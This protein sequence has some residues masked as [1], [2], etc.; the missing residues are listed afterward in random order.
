[1]TDKAASSIKQSLIK[2]A[3]ANLGAAFFILFALMML[4]SKQLDFFYT[5]IVALIGLVG[6]LFAA[7]A[8]SQ[9]ATVTLK[10][11]KNEKKHVSN[12]LIQAKDMLDSSKLLK[13]EQVYYRALIDSMPMQAWVLNEKGQYVLL[14]RLHQNALNLETKQ[15]IGQFEDEQSFE[16]SKQC[17][18]KMQEVKSKEF[19]ENQ[20]KSFETIRLPIEGKGQTKNSVVVFRYLVTDNS[21]KIQ[22]H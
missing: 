10:F 14:N 12:A 20:R 6:L 21:N 5:T 2:M 11:S 7:Y 22:K 13:E 16:L 17:L 15:I 8:F 1:M 18:Q 9:F 19:D 3:V 4:F